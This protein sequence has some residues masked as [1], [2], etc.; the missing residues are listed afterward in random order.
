MA[1][2]PDAPLNQ[3][4]V[5]VSGMGAD[6]HDTTPPGAD[7]VSIQ[8]GHEPDKFRAKGI[9]YV[10]MFVVG[11]VLFAFAV[12]TSIF[13]FGVKKA[14]PD[15]N[16]NTAV[17]EAQAKPFSER[18]AKI[19]SSDKN[20]A[21]AQPRLEYF[22][23]VETAPNDPAQM[24]SKRPVDVPGGT[25][26]IRPEDLR[27]ENFI[28]PTFRRKILIERRVV[29]AD[30][31]LVAIPIEDAMNLLVSKHLLPVS[32]NPITVATTNAEKAKPSNGGRG[33]PSM[34]TSAPAPK[35]EAKH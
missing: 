1:H 35:V 29:D 26:E 19:S 33:G 27:A 17:V 16:S 6:E 5:S 28:D 14:E 22:K 7:K 34:P 24:R 30:K 9:L 23:A 31:K 8:A 4:I 32:K 20:A 25:Y 15:A 12:I 18:I 11:T 21:V 10:P 2:K 13:A 3:L